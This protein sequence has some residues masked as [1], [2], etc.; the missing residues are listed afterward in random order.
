MSKDIDLNKNNF[1]VKF[2][3]TG[4][5][6]GVPMVACNCEICL[7]KNPKNKRD[8]PSIFIKFNNLNIVVDTGQDFRHQC[9]KNQLHDIDAVLYTHAHMDHITGFDD[10]RAFTFKKGINMPIY[11]TEN[12]INSIKNIFPYAFDPNVQVK[13]YVKPSV[14][15]IENNKEFYLS[16]NNT[17]LC[18][19]PIKVIHGNIDTIGFIFKSGDK[20]TF[21]YIPDCKKI[22]ASSL[23]SMQ[24]IETLIIDA[25][26]ERPHNTHMNFMEATQIHDIIKPKQTYFTHLTHFVDHNK[27]QKQLAK[28]NKNIKLAYDGLELHL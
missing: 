23:L 12:T 3:G 4:T 1:F 27:A 28:L 6:M 17:Q 20:K 26:H 25:L 16:K 13:T 5:S 8:R 7:S 10:L 11:G 14:N 21:A 9:I 18:I 19:L 24:N 15:I 22:D 2:L